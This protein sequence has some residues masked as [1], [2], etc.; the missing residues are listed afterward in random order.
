[1]SAVIQLPTSAA[2][3]PTLAAPVS[4]ARVVAVRASV[5]EHCERLGLSDDATR[6]SIAQAITQ[7]TNDLSCWSAISFG[8]EFADR[9]KV[10]TG[11]MK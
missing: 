4:T 9:Q 6:A 8:K 5:R 1:M 11:A 10:R 7:L 3:R 2:P